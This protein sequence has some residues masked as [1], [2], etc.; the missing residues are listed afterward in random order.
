MTFDLDLWPTD[1]KINRDHLLIKDYLPT[2]FEASGAKPSWVISCTRLRATDIP[3]DMCNAICPSFF[4]GG[5][6]KLKMDDDRQRVHKPYKDITPLF[7]LTKLRFVIYSLHTCKM[8]FWT[9][10][11]C[12]CIWTLRCKTWVKCISNLRPVVKRNMNSFDIHGTLHA[13]RENRYLSKSGTS[14]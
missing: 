8:T 7:P 9:T 6:K 5:H 13:Y 11:R 3:T 4:K 1:L 14:F 12:E 10:D 2:K